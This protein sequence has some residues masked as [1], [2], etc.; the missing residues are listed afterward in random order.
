MCNFFQ[1]NF[2]LKYSWFTMSCQL[3]YS[4]LT[5]S[6]TYIY[7][8]SFLFFFFLGPHLQ[9]VKVLSLGVELELQ[10][11]AYATAT[12]I[13]D[14]SCVCDLHHSS[15]QYWIPDPLSKA[16]GWTCILT[17]TSQIHFRCTH[18]GNSHIPFLTLSSITVHPKRLDIAPP[19][20][21]RRTSL[22]I[23]S[24]CNS[25]HLPI[26]NSQAIP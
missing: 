13:R 2:K 18:N 3:L 9:H 24:K 20:L 6:H 16:R 8:L 7:S 17:D 25:L 19:V 4:K 15:R 10:L 12:A 1:L 14:W 22:L 26:P 23:H 11:L 21:Y 5:Q